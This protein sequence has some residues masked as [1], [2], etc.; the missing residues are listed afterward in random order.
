MSID[1][2]DV[3]VGGGTQDVD[4][5]TALHTIASRLAGLET[6]LDLALRKLQEVHILVSAVDDRQSELD[7]RVMVM[8]DREGF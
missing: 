3:V 5:S 7:E 8:L 2:Q 1:I 4:I 6:R